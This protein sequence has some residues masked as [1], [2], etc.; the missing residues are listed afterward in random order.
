METVEDKNVKI[1]KQVADAAAGEQPV[2]EAPVVEAPEVAAPAVADVAVKPVVE[3]VAPVAAAVPLNYEQDAVLPK[4]RLSLEQIG[5]I[6]PQRLVAM[7][8]TLQGK[9][10]AEVPALMIQNK[11]LQHELDQAGTVPAAATVKPLHEVLTQEEREELGDE[12]VEATAKMVGQ[13]REEYAGELQKIRTQAFGDSV[14]VLCPRAAEL[15]TDP[16][17]HAWLQGDVP[18]SGNTR[19]ELLRAAH[20]TLNA[21]RVVDIFAAYIAEVEG[22]VPEH[23]LKEIVVPAA[24]GAPEAVAE[25]RVWRESDVSA[26]YANAVKG[27]VT[28]E[29]FIQTE[30][31]INAALASGSIIEG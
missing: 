13:V 17:F 31:E 6:E 20:S 29:E 24:I 7:Y 2:V 21:A 19:F 8:S 22:V 27:R 3:V 12:A 4:E 23:E 30:A 5:A 26:F 28:P 18:L 10:H 1:P 9:Y 14:R 25:A 16:A 15:N 11:A